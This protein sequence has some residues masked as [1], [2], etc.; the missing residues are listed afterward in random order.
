MDARG[1][2]F[3]I[4]R[5]RRVGYRTLLAPALLVTDGDYTVLAD[6]VEPGAV[7]DR[8]GIIDLTTP[9]GQPIS[10][11]H[12]THRV[13]GTDLG[14]AAAP[15]DEHGR[16]LHL[17]YG[18][19]C[20]RA[21]GICPDQADLRTALTAALEAYQ[22]FLKDEKDFAI[23]VGEPFPLRS[24]F[25]TA[26]PAQRPTVLCIASA[27]ALLVVLLLALR[28]VSAPDEH[29]PPDPSPTVTSTKPC[30]PSSR[31]PTA[32]P[33]RS[34]AGHGT[35]TPFTCG[36][37]RTGIR[38][39]LPTRQPPAIGRPVTTGTA[40]HRARTARRQHTAATATPRSPSGNTGAAST[41]TASGGGSES[42]PPALKGDCRRRPYT[43]ACPRTASPI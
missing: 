8:P 41:A 21:R 1:W 35:V 6:H 26:A 3:L 10:V 25:E 19:V 31:P 17:L 14:Q 4:S 11:V 18:F 30:T 28:W 34:A 37:E 24:S 20:P 27:A 9:S 33:S 32:I 43:R 12:A 23:E 22:S 2:P 5:G 38:P 40:S 36:V 39:P 15:K 42:D 16:P 29:T 7:L 13:S